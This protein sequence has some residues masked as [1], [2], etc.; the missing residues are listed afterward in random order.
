MMKVVSEL[1]RKDEIP[2]LVSLNS[3]MIDGT[4]MCGC[5]RVDV[6]GQ[7]K[8]VCVDGPEFDGHK[9]DFDLLIKRLRAFLPQEQ[10]A[11]QRFIAS[12]KCRATEGAQNG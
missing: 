3:I 12:H 10:E 2:T 11:R 8:F 5:C 9:V 7:T 4:G 1:T 6:G